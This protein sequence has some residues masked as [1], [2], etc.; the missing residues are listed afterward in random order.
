MKQSRYAFW[1]A[2]ALGCLMDVLVLL[3]FNLL[4]L[5][6]PRVAAPVAPGSWPLTWARDRAD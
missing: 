6:D 5:D 1:R 3:Q 4:L 2:V